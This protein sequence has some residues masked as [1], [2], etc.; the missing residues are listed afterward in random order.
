M[1]GP[2]RVFAQKGMH[3][4]EVFIYEGVT[5]ALVYQHIIGGDAGL[6]GIEGLAPCKAFCGQFDVG[7]SGYEARALAAELQHHRGQVL[8]G[9]R[10]HYPAQAGTS[11]K[12]DD[13]PA[14]LQQG[15]IDIAVALHHGDI[16]LIESVFHHLRYHAGDVGNV[17]GRLQE[18]RTAGG[19]GA[20]QRV[21]QQL[22]RV[23]PRGDDERASKRLGDYTAAGRTHLHRSRLAARAGPAGEVAEMI[24]DFAGHD[25]HLC[26][27]CFLL[28]F[29]Q[30]GPEGLV[31]GFL[32]LFYGGKKLAEHAFPECDVARGAGGVVFPL[33]SVQLLDA[34][35]GILNHH[36]CK[37]T[38]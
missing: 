10:H 34:F 25:T 32:P 3:L 19:D 8:R 17:W 37:F 14:L 12:E 4:T 15:G 30:I 29:V 13:I 24:P 28:R 38:Q 18:G 2:L 20:H 31:K 6:A 7:V 35:G 23:V 16:A 9:R 22:E 11:G 26:Q 27:E 21:H 5:Y 33:E 36:N 1:L